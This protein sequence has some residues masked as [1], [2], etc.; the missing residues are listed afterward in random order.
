[1]MKIFYALFVIVFSAFSLSAQFANIPMDMSDCN[2][3]IFINDKIIPPIKY[4]KQK[5]GGNAFISGLTYGIAKCHNKNFYKG[6]HSPNIVA[7]GDTITFKFG[8]VPS[9][10][11]NTMH[12]FAGE[13]SINNFIIAKMNSKKDYRE[14]KTASISLWNGIDKGTNSSEDIQFNIINNSLNSCSIVITN[15]KA[16]DYCFIFSDNANGAFEYIY[17]FYVKIDI[18]EKDI[19]K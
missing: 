11:V 5:I 12:V 2:V 4:Y 18:N 9:K 8:T 14:L 7:V 15:I 17:D 19:K 10:Y 1:M 16:G 13:Y 6:Q 3:G